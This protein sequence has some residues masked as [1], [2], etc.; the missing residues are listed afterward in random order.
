MPAPS[1]LP[2]VDSQS[3]K[4]TNQRSLNPFGSWFGGGGQ[5]A[6]GQAAQIR[7]NAASR[8]GRGAKLPVVP[9]TVPANAAATGSVSH[10]R[11]WRA[12]L[13]ANW[14]WSRI[15]KDSYMKGIESTQI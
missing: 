3:A 5:S 12:V 4:A 10:I 7:P 1:R 9:G 11:I 8:S 15:L 6:T 14:A 13:Y 2:N